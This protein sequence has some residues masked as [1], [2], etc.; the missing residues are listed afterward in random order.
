MAKCDEATPL[1]AP[2]CN[3]CTKVACGVCNSFLWVSF[4]DI[5]APRRRPVNY[6]RACQPS[7]L[8][9][10]MRSPATNSNR[11][12]VCS[13]PNSSH[14]ISTHPSTMASD[15]WDIVSGTSA[16]SD[17]RGVSRTIK[18]EGVRGAAP[19]NNTQT[20]DLRLTD[21]D[22]L[23]T[24]WDRIE[25]ALLPQRIRNIA[26]TCC[27]SRRLSASTQYSRRCWAHLL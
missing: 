10:Y 1:C 23:T 3:S 7:Q 27:C 9:P 26:L 5:M 19:A 2:H 14:S 25:G 6:C 11:S 22:I 20:I 15:D 18:I 12:N 21:E 16:E 17:A 24:L 13:Q 4:R 8:R